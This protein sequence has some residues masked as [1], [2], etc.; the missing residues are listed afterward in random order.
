MRFAM[1]GLN[2]CV[3]WNWGEHRLEADVLLDAIAKS[4]CRDP[5]ISVR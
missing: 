3:S 5:F 1:R 4:Q 2:L